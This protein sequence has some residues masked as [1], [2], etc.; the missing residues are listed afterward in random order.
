MG[1]TLTYTVNVSNSGP[2][3]ATNVTAKVPLP[4]GLTFSTATASQGSYDPTTGIWT[5]GSVTTA[6]VPT[7]TLTAAV[8]LDSAQTTTAAISSVEQYDPDPLAFAQSVT[9]TP[10]PAVVTSGDV[11]AGQP[12]APIIGT[13]I[14]GSNGTTSA[15][16][17]GASTSS[18]SSSG[19]G[20]NSGNSGSNSLARGQSRS[21]GSANGTK[22]SAHAH[23]H[24]HPSP[25]PSPH[26]NG[27]SPPI[28]V[29]IPE[30]ALAMHALAAPPGGAGVHGN[31]AGA[32]GVQVAG[33]LPA[34]PL[35]ARA[36]AIPFGNS[37]LSS[38]QN[39]N[40]AF[41]VNDTGA[42]GTTMKVITFIQA[43]RIWSRGNKSHHP[44][45]RRRF[46]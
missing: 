29:I 18:S 43:Q 23:P 42:V 13:L 8:A 11:E 32:A 3:S 26:A 2:D 36:T 37:S 44:S 24:P 1:E 16:G 46:R 39:L 27:P 17:S 19:S 34:Q 9:V 14:T 38:V 41:A 7:L 22:V 20:N 35:I 21:S 10:E 4:S 25:H 40:T 33:G 30:N 12:F 5:L 28:V 31:A 15:S 45:S 6:V